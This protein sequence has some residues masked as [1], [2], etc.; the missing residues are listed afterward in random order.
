M[1]KEANGAEVD[2]NNLGERMAQL[3]IKAVLFDLDETLF[4]TYFFEGRRIFKRALEAEIGEDLSE[5]KFMDDWYKLWKGLKKDHGVHPRANRIVSEMMV[6]K[7][8]RT[9]MTEDLEAAYV[10]MCDLIYHTVPEEQPGMKETIE[11]LKQAGIG[12]YV[13]THAEKEWTE[14]KLSNWQ[15]TFDG[16]FC[17]DVLGEKDVQAWALAMEEFCLSPVEVAVVGDNVEADLLPVARL[18]VRYKFRMSASWG[19]S[20]KLPAETVEVDDLEQIIEFFLKDEEL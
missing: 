9:Q 1:S 18:G 14:F 11:A 16:V 7:Y 12:V 6:E 13:V 19:P 5:D 8:G 10:A 4:K 3:G 17:V 20:S 15:G 2:E